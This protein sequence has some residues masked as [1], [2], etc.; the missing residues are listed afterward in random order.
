MRPAQPDITQVVHR[1]HTEML[2]ERLL[3]GARADP[4]V[5]GGAKRVRPATRSPMSLP[6]ADSSAD[7]SM[8]THNAR[9]PV[10]Q[11][12]KNDPPPGWYTAGEARLISMCSPQCRD[13]NSPEI[14]S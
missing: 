1:R 3:Q 11:R 14:G 13:S 9:Y 4:A 2:L 5:L 7:A 6:M 10:G 8:R 12:P